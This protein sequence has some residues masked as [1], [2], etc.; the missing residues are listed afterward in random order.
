MDFIV[1]VLGFY[2]FRIIILRIKYVMKI[3][4]DYIENCLCI[5]LSSCINSWR[6]SDDKKFSS[7]DETKKRQSEA[8]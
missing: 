3:K 6:K 1:I 4:E 2:A 5:L 7:K 8:I